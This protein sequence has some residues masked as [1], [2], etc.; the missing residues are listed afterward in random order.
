METE[1]TFMTS[2]EVCNML[3]IKRV[4]LWRYTKSGILPYY[5]VGRKLLFK[6]AEIETAI[7]VK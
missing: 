7:Q 3:N 4:A 6:K 2:S 5:K 1:K